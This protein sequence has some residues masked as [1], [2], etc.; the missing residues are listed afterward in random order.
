MKK[1]AKSIVRAI[2]SSPHGRLR[3]RSCIPPRTTA[4]SHAAIGLT[5]AFLLG[6]T[7]VAMA[8]QFRQPGQSFQ[9]QGFGQ[10]GGF[11]QQPSAIPSI[12]AAAQP[13]GVTEAAPEE[14]VEAD[15]SWVPGW[16]SS[17]KDQISAGGLLMLPLGICSFIVIGLICE[18]LVSLRRSRVIPR[19]FVRRFREK[20]EDGQLDIE[21][22][23]EV[24]ND[25]DCAVADVF[26][27]AVKRTG[28]PMV[29]IEAAVFDALERTAD[30]LRRYLRVFHAVSNV[31]PLIG[32]LGT[33]LGMIEAFETMASEAGMGHPELLAI[34]ISKALVTTAGGLCVAIPAYLA[35]MYFSSRADGY[36]A[37]IER[38]S[39]GVID[40]VSAESAGGGAKTRRRK[41]A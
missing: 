15:S 28:R 16:A 26:I 24:C 3:N 5:L 10:Q 22:A 37:E 33:V 2:V 32:L 14:A 1:L 27:A 21:E 41:A 12:P 23:T 34:G 7:P 38:L 29:E 20:V 40:A 25:F 39:L 9:Q 36:L 31:A 18:R 13:Q 19:P 11:A 35:Y 6:A 8:Q 17:L 4:P 30:G